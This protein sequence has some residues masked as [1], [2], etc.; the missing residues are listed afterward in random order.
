MSSIYDPIHF[1][2]LAIFP[3][4]V[5]EYASQL[6]HFRTF[7]CSAVSHV[8]WEGPT[9]APLLM[10]LATSSSSV[11]RWHRRVLSPPLGGPGEGEEGHRKWWS[12][13]RSVQKFLA[14]DFLKYIDSGMSFIYS[15]HMLI[16]GSWSKLF[17]NLIHISSDFCTGK[18]DSKG[19]A[20]GEKTL[21]DFA[22][23]YAKSNRSTCKGCEQKIE[24]VFNPFYFHRKITEQS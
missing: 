8:W 11:H 5:R 13:R 14:T 19:G 1:L 12:N 3:W 4:N 2:M 20:K 6:D 17:M 22:V 9:L 16:L 18:G 7:L 21:N 23:E 15:S 24:K 10:L